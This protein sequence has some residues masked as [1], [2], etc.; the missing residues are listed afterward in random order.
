MKKETKLKAVT[1]KKLP[2]DKLSA[3]QTA[4]LISERAKQSDQFEYDDPGE[5]REI[6]DKLPEGEFVIK[7]GN[8]T[9]IQKL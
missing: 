8:K 7:E 4:K 2:E 3:S 1:E 5:A 6:F 9:V